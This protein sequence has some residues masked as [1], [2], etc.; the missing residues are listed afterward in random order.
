[1][2]FRTGPIKQLWAV[3]LSCAGITLF[4]QVLFA[5]PHERCRA[6]LK[7]HGSPPPIPGL[8]SCIYDMDGGTYSAPAAKKCLASILGSGYFNSGQIVKHEGNGTVFLDFVLT[9]P[10]LRVTKVEYRGID[11]PLRSR[12]ADWLA[13]TNDP[14]QVGDTYTERRDNRT[15]QILYMFFWDLGEEVGIT[16][17][18]T[19]DYRNGTAEVSYTVTPGPEMTPIRGLPPYRGACPIPISSFS[20][21]D[22]D[23]YVP[24][25]IVSRLTKTHPWGCFDAATVVQDEQSLERSGL[26]RSASLEATNDGEGKEIEWHVRGKELKVA[27]VRII[28]Y[29]RFAGRTFEVPPKLPLGPGDTYRRSYAY[30]DL[31][32]IQR[33]V[34]KPNETVLVFQTDQASRG[35]EVKVTFNVLAYD[36]DT[37]TING[38]EFRRQAQMPINSD[39][40]DTDAAK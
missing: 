11:N 34:Q 37:V 1:M 24:K 2:R 12:L 40:E 7:G 39:W 30:T 3:L 15:G 35:E 8:Y 33:Q 27:D 21:T 25:G 5:A 4:V 36:N 31:R 13:K 16:I 23:D 10:A 32:I 22:I 38:H 29:G 6:S 19:L 28:G 18:P 14:L 26:F 17:D 20:L 9:A